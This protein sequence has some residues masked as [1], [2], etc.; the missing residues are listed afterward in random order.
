MFTRSSTTTADQCRSPI[1]VHTSK[2][3]PG[4]A[5]TSSCA[6]RSAS[7]K[8]TIRIAR[9]TS[10]WKSTASS[11]SASSTPRRCGRSD[12]VTRLA[13]GSTGAQVATRTPAQ[14]E[15][16]TF[17]SP[18]T[19]LSVSTLARNSTFEFWTTTGCTMAQLFAH[20]AASSAENNL[21]SQ[22]RPA[23]SPKRRR[24]ATTIRKTT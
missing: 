11:R 15:E 21:P 23:K 7:L 6:A 16:S 14:V 24:Q 5:R 4:A 1:T 13:S 2:S 19:R 8:R 12:H 10:P 22:A 20:P 3:L 17:T 18:T 9:K